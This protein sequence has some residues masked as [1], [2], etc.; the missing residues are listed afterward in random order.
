MRIEKLKEDLAARTGVKIVVWA[1]LFGLLLM[2]ILW[3]FIFLSMDKTVRT[4]LTPPDVQKSFWVDGRTLGPEHLELMGGYIIREF[5]S[6]SPSSADQQLGTILK[7]V[8]PSVHGELSVRFRMSSDKLKRE[9]ISRVFWP[10]EVRINQQKLSMAMIGTLDTWIVDKKVPN[11]EMKAYLV[12]FEYRD[13]RTTIKELREA[14]PKDPFG[15]PIENKQEA[16]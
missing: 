13:G 7:M 5:A 3:G 15:A 11:P 2:N 6:I 14:D 4:V 8:H 9:Q 1:I 10:K 16:M 12:V